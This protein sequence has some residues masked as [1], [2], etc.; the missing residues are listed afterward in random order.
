MHVEVR[1]R[2]VQGDCGIVCPKD[3]AAN[4]KAFLSGDRLM[5]VYPV[6]EQGSDTSKFWIIPEADRSVTMVLLPEDY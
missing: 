6:D 1:E 3:R 2:H 5:S 4:E